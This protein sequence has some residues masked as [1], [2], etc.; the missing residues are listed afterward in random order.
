MKNKTLDISAV[1]VSG[2][3]V[4]NVS[5]LDREMSV[6]ELLDSLVPKMRLPVL[7]NGR[8]IT[9]HARHDR[10]G[11]HLHASQLLADT[12]LEDEDRITV[13]PSIQAG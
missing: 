5:R 3:N 11:Q 13:Q 10:T 9:Y 2:Q 7:G 12:G 1:D 4:V 8:R 6:G